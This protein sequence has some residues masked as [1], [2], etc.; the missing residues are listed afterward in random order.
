MKTALL[1]I[2]Q[3]KGID[4]PKLGLRNNPQA[5]EV[6]LGVLS[7]WRQK[8]RQNQWPIVHIK[9]RSKDSESVFWPHQTGFEFKNEFLPIEGE[10]VLEKTVPCAFTNNTFENLLR[11]TGVT[12]LVIVGVATNNSVES[13]ART[14]GNLGFKVTVLEDGCYTFAKY[15]YDGNL[16][17]A[18]EVHAMSLANLD[19]E[20]AAVKRASAL[21]SALKI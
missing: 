21:Y 18:Q 7:R 16:R 2:D 1:I 11:E 9:H 19:G 20:Y 3:Q 8:W 17:S 13:T 15:D 6:M 10:V 5:E 12:D 4:H 14:G